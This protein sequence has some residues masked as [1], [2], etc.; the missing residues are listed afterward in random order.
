MPGRREQ[1]R[2]VESTGPRAPTARRGAGQ[3][4]PRG[5]LVE[6][7]PGYGSP[8]QDSCLGNSKDRGAWRATVHGLAES[9]TRLCDSLSLFSLYI[10][11]SHK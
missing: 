5:L 1:S 4:E 10:L 7:K 11:Q 2:L 3:G 6:S 8:L 9:R